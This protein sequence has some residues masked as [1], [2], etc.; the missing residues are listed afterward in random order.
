AVDIQADEKKQ[1]KPV[2]K[3]GALRDLPGRRIEVGQLEGKGPDELPGDPPRLDKDGRWNWGDRSNTWLLSAGPPSGAARPKP[4]KQK[5]EK[6]AIRRLTDW[7]PSLK[8]A[9]VGGLQGAF[10]AALQEARA[11]LE[12]GIEN[13]TA[14]QAVALGDAAGQRLHKLREAGTAVNDL[15]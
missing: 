12:G 15:K 4:Q 11:G 7:I 2:E 1:K 13:V 10:E 8:T 9:G 14:E 3:E 5:G 6:K